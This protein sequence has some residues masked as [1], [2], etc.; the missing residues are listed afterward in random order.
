[1][2]AMEETQL[3]KPASLCVLLTQWG[4]MGR[5]MDEDGK[6]VGQKVGQNDGKR[7]DTRTGIKMTRRLDKRI[8]LEA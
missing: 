4:R 7:L 8:V 2:G 5:R 3:P 6:Q 1:M